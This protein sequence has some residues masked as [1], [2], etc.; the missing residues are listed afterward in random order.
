MLIDLRDLEV[1]EPAVPFLLPLIE[2]LEPAAVLLKKSAPTENGYDC[3][4]WLR[5]CPESMWVSNTAGHGLT[6][7]GMRAEYQKLLLLFFAPPILRFVVI[8]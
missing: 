3:C 5:C 2:G 8:L 1:V 7:L 4:E 6:Q